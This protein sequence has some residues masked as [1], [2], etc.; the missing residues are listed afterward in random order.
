[1]VIEVRFVGHATV[2]LTSPETK[3]LTDPL[4]RTRISFLRRLQPPPGPTE[5]P[6]PDVVLLS[7]LHQD[8]TDLPSLR[9]IG[10][11]AEVVAPPGAGAFLTDAGI[12]NVT[13]SMVG[14]ARQVSPDTTITAVPAVH[15]G[16]RPPMGPEATAV[17]YLI[18]MAGRRIYFAGDT[19]IFPEMAYLGPVDLA[20]LPVWGWGPNL[21][22][23]HMDPA[24]AAQAAALIGAR[25]ALP[26]HWGTY[27]PLG[28]RQAL[29]GAARFLTEPPLEFARRAAEIAPETHVI[30]LDPGGRCDLWR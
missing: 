4:L 23:G 17:G 13:E 22:P 1:M 5:L 28:M 7:H 30:L 6:R 9:M 25:A 20:L 11:R 3:V 12:E 14:D 26:I 21:G 16:S 24:G 19:D 18:E 15:D 29:R 27:F 2:A 8:H 10:A